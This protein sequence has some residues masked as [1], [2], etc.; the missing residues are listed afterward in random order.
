MKNIKKIISVIIASIITMISSQLTVFAKADKIDPRTFWIETQ[1]MDIMD[2][3]QNPTL[4]LTQN[5]LLDSARS[6]PSSV[7]LTA[8]FPTPGDQGTQLSCTGWAV[9]YA[10]QAQSE[11]TKRNWTVNQDNHKFSPSFLYNQVYLDTNDTTPTIYKVLSK[12]YYTGC[13]P[14]TYF[15]Y[16]ETNYTNAPTNRQ[17]S[18]AALYKTSS[19]GLVTGI[20]NM[21]GKLNQGYGIVISIKTYSDFGA[22]N[23]S[24][25]VYDTI[26]TSETPGN[27]AICLIGYNDSMG[28][29]GA[30]KF[31]NSWGTGWGLSGY[32]WISYNILSQV[33]ILGVVGG[34]YLN[35]S[36][37]DNYMM[38][39][40]DGDG[41]ITVTDSRLALRQ[42][43]G[44]ENLSANQYVLADV[45]G[46]GSVEVEDAQ[47]ILAVSVGSQTTFSLYI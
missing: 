30:F 41:E 27:H 10:A 15:P 40:V 17:R 33:S 26:N 25:P 20:A 31:I 18:A 37:S 23:S 7:D 12:L 43:V 13:C 8:Q 42:S 45:N 24:N 9:G 14:W 38:G 47:E 21:K 32:G 22:I 5:D 29:S 35:K 28:S 34:Y 6:L 39:D 2:Y 4:G 46:D 16:D 1:E 19:F 36:A 44:L 3:I 11:K